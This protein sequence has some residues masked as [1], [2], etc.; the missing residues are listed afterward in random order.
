M[1]NDKNSIPVTTQNNFKEYNALETF[2]IVSGASVR[3]KNI[4]RDIWE[5]IKSLFGAELHSYSDLIERSRED[6]V[7]RMQ[8]EAT[9]RGANA[10]V[11]TRISTS[12]IAHGAA[13]VLSYGTAV[14]IVPKPKK[15]LIQK[16]QKTPD[17]KHTNQLQQNQSKQAIAI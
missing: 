16:D 14:F 10:V 1:I 11:G 3:T 13:E 7:R 17:I 8:K 15:S 12:T 6:A 2:G 4:F 9:E 5:S